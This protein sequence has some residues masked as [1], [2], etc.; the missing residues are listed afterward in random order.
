MP[1]NH[2]D[3]V[4]YHILFDNHAETVCTQK[5]LSILCTV[6]NHNQKDP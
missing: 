1:V 4:H 6:I 5:Y 2:A 3:E